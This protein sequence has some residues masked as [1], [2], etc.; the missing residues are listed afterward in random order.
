MN[1]VEVEVLSSLTDIHRENV[2]LPLTQ[3]SGLRLRCIGSCQEQ[4]HVF[5]PRTRRDFGCREVSAHIYDWADQR[6]WPP[7]R[8]ASVFAN[9][10]LHRVQLVLLD[11][12][13]SNVHHGVEQVN[14]ARMLGL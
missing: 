6:V 2:R 4:A 7:P 12:L 5:P 9:D 11:L 10:D 13:S 1:V 14:R 3:Y 8:S